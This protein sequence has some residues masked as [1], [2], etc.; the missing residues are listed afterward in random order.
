MTSILRTPLLLLIFSAVCSARAFARPKAARAVFPASRNREAF[1]HVANQKPQIAKTAKPAAALAGIVRDPAGAAVAGARVAFHSTNFTARQVT[2]RRGRFNFG[3]IPAAAGVLRVTAPG[4]ATARQ[5]WRAAA[6]ARQ[7]LVITLTPAPLEQTVTVTATR[8][9]TPLG[10]TAADVLVLT[11]E[12][13]ASAPALTLDDLLRQIPGFT[14]FR[15]SG[16]RTANPTSQGVS[17]RGVGAS[18]A[19]RALVLADGI[20][21]NDPF[22][23][24]VYWDRV[25]RAAVER[26]EV[27]RGGASD[28]YGTTAM[29]GVINFITRKAS[30][31]GLT[32]D[33]SYGNED[34]P[35]ASL[36][37]GISRGAWNASFSGEVMS[38]DGYVL[39]APSERGSVDTPAAS[40]HETADLRLERRVSA[41]GS[42]FGEASI[43]RETRQNGT[44]LQYNRTHLRQLVFGVNWQTADVG[45]VSVRA[46]GGAQL[47]D[48]TFS[49]V[50]ADRNSES[51]VDSQRVPAQ[52]AGL[53][54]QWSRQ[55][56]SRQTLVA[57]FDA[58]QVRGASDE[59]GFFRGR[60]TRATGSGGQQGNESVF[61]EDILQLTPRWRA[62]VA[63]R[64]DRWKNF[65]ALSTTRPI[66]TSGPVAAVHFPQRIESAFSPR[67]AT[68]YRLT[69]N[70][71]LTASAYGAFRAPTLNEL[72]RNFR[73]GDVETLAN[74]SLRAERLTGAEAGAEWSPFH[75]KL[76]ARGTF[77][78]S[79]ISDPIANVTL[80]VAPSLITRERENLGR[81]RARGF[82]LEVTADVKPALS[83]EAGY[84]LAD[85][86]V[87]SFPANPA[88]VG[89]RVPEIPRNSFSF[90]ALY[91]NPLAANSL[92]RWTLS[93]QG[94]FTGM[95]FDD[96]LNQLPLGSFFTVDAFLARALGRQL[97]AYVAAENLNDSRYAIARTPVL[98]V[99]PPAL[100][101]AGIKVNFGFR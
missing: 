58:R 67:L 86:T 20:P 13:V 75:R 98:E 60:A 99:G 82:D 100:V 81:T 10:Q 5:S 69:G 28:L 77:F 25:P 16:S 54:V 70:L 66:S 40:E 31:P 91:S 74:S 3:S 34:T 43:F 72:Y 44:P 17:L 41:G 92:K 62:T 57:G 30:H 78:W 61:G 21:L 83:L 55:A 64:L 8:T 39:A 12:E 48:Q 50:A 52:Q 80:S 32:L 15:R 29:G 11:P 51:L 90:Q 24:W 63:A 94:R 38:T 2:G 97:Q 23:G 59:I 4:F 95:A 87:L 42:V 27:V 46:Y 88:L 1:A 18:G 19:S 68:L 37:T 79:D 14:L 101:R 36:W 84:E 6:A 56:G 22:G 35:D 45:L 96:D 53:D 7:P 65:D 47:F 9:P 49:S 76:T 73:L 89:L 33:T 26:V 85:A 93:F 71:A